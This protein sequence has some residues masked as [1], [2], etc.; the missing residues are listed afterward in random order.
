M[1]ASAVRSFAAIG[2]SFTEGMGDE[3]P[4][5]TPRGWADFVAMALAA[6]AREP[7]GYANLAIRGRKLG[8]ILDEQLDAAIA[9][10]PQLLS[11]N[12]GG[13]DMM[14][15]KISIQETSGRLEAAVDKVL[16]AGP[17]MLMLSGANPSRNL[18]GGRLMRKRGDALSDAVAVWAARKDGVVYVDNWHDESIED[19]AYWSPDKLH[20]N[21][22]GHTR[23]ASN[24][25]H[26][27]GVPVPASWGVDEV[28]DAIAHGNRPGA[29]T[30]YREFVL[31]WIGR[32]LTGRSSGDGRVAKRATL[33]LIEP[34]AL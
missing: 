19:L 18:P 8:P 17:T 25:L 29:I 31:P 6:H 24:V 28:E 10:R 12:G 11:M 2:D 1:D 23:V 9:L 32:R 33:M 15:P 34:L 14:R 7:I 21:A 16:A 27:L 30:Y 20:L 26:G 5:G 13:N 4:D 22:L 3:L